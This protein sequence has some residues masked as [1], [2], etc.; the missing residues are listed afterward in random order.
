MRRNLA[1]Y[2]LQAGNRPTELNRSAYLPVCF[3]TN[4]TSPHVLNNMSR[5]TP[6]FSA[7]DACV[8]LSVLKPAGTMRKIKAF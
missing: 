3:R 4:A 7:L 8:C 1:A 6:N 5:A 2:R